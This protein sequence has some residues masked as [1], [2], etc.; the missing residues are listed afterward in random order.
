MVKNIVNL[1]AVLQLGI[2]TVAITTNALGV[3]TTGPIPISLENIVIEKNPWLG[4]KSTIPSSV[5]SRQT[6]IPGPGWIRL[7]RPIPKSPI[8]AGAV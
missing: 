1:I 5:C 2:P 4:N 6:T 8:L 7:E 3:E